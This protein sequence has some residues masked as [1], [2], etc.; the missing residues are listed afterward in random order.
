VALK[1]FTVNLHDSRSTIH[2]VKL[3]VLRKFS[4]CSSEQFLEKNSGNNVFVSPFRV[5]PPEL[6]CVVLRKPVLQK[7]FTV[8]FY[9]LLRMNCDCSP[10][11]FLR[12]IG[13][14][15]MTGGLSPRQ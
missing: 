7:P 1:S 8:Q 5:F 11:M 4:I 9:E 15:L 12:V 2:A 13:D 3:E 14:K 10:A 6:P